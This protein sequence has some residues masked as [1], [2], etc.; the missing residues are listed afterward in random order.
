MKLLENRTQRGWLASYFCW[1]VA[2]SLNMM[3]M[4]LFPRAAI[5][6]CHKFGGLIKR[7]SSSPSSGG[8]KFEI[9]VA[10]GLVP[11][12]MEGDSF[13]PLSWALLAVPSA[14]CLLMHQPSPCSS[15]HGIWPPCV[16]LSVQIYPLYKDT[17]HTGLGAHPTPGW[18]HLN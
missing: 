4:Y 17:I 3:S 15:L 7:K 2:V 16:F 14:L 1:I 12:E 5:T 8:W 13:T 9:R 6:K 18:P 10:A 11:S